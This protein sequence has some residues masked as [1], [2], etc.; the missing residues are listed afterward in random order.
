MKGESNI[1]DRSREKVRLVLGIY[2]QLI[3]VQLS[4]THTHTQTHSNTI[5]EQNLF[6]LQV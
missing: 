2:S 3:Y 6:P 4:H 1:I 5:D